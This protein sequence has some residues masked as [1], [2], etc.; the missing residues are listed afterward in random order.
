MFARITRFPRLAVGFALAVILAAGVLTRTAAAFTPQPDPP[1]GMVGIVA[2]QTARLNL[3]NTASPTATV[4]PDPCRARLRFLDADG[5][6]VAR[7]VA[8][9][10]PGQATFLDFSPSTVPVNTLG[11]VAG[12]IR[13]EIRASVTFVDGQ[14]PPD[15][16]RVNVEIFDN[17]SG[18]TTVAF[19]PD[20][21]RGA[22]CRADQ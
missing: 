11:A 16:C 9:V 12:P 14:V 8:E 2:G 18:R 19:P 17:A 5:N 15:P 22:A 1:F 13:S 7:L 20:P 3:V 21:C 10:Q 6:V 4:P